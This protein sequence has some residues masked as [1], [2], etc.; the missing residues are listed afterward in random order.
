[1]TEGTREPT[2]PKPSRLA[3]WID[4]NGRPNQLRVDYRPTGTDTAETII[5]LKTEAGKSTECRPS[6]IGQ[7]R[8]GCRDRDVYFEIGHAY[9]AD[10]TEVGRKKVQEW[11]AF[12]RREAH[13]I[14]EYKRLKLKFGNEVGNDE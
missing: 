8:H 7:D 9:V 10:L 6:E 1:M 5:T 12:Q 14:A 3:L 11:K 13:D 2:P 4:A